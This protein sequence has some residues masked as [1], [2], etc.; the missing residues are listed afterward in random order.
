VQKIIAEPGFHERMAAIGVDV[1][2]TMPAAYAKII[3][4]DYAKWGKVN[5]AAGIKPEGAGYGSRS[6]QPKLDQLDARAPRVGDVG[7]RR[8]GPH[9][10]AVR[11]VEL[12]ALG[13][14]L[15]DE[16]RQVLYVETDVIEHA[17]AGRSLRRID[18]GEPELAAR[19]VD[20]RLVVARADL[21]AEGLRVPGHGFG[22]LRL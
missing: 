12:D 10:L 22:N 1:V 14:D 2:G 11:L 6:S 3:S 19:N 13:F 15:L 4:D 17:P 16:G 8:A 18:F 5:P 7:D 21:A 9:D 20:D